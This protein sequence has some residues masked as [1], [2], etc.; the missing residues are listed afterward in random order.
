LNYR[1]P[2]LEAIL[3]T[4]IVNHAQGDFIPSR[5]KS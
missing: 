4:W 1:P 5:S 2:T 3:T